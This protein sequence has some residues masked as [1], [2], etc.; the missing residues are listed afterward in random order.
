MNNSPVKINLSARESNCAVC[1]VVVADCAQGIPFYEG[2]PVSH[3]WL[4]PWIGRDACTKCFAAYEASQ[5]RVVASPGSNA[6]AWRTDPWPKDGSRFVAIFSLVDRRRS[7]CF[8]SSIVS[9]VSYH[10]EDAEFYCQY[11][12]LVN[13][14]G[15]SDLV[16]HGWLPMPEFPALDFTLQF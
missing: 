7:G 6:A 5:P 2:Q 3:D 9:V 16:N 14:D 10:P 13:P 8:V 4:G 1:G 15:S 12:G 11:D